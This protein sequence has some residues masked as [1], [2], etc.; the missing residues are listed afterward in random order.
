MIKKNNKKLMYKFLCKQII[1]FKEERTKMLIDEEN[2]D[3][4]A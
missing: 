1:I 4:W 3:E 2:D